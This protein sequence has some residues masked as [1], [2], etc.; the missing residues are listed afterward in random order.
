MTE[1]DLLSLSVILLIVRSEVSVRLVHQ[2]IVGKYPGHDFLGIP[3]VNQHVSKRIVE[4]RDHDDTARGAL[5]FHYNGVGVGCDDGNALILK[6]RRGGSSVVAEIVQQ[7]G[8]VGRPQGIRSREP[9][10]HESRLPNHDRG[11]MLASEPP[12]TSGPAVLPSPAGG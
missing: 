10:D 8:P 1:P 3:R 5:G 12:E 7:I 2:L 6:P 11:L 9:E 4:P